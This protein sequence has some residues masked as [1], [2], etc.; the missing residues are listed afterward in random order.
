MREV[1]QGQWDSNT[2]WRLHETAELPPAALCTAVF[3][4]ALTTEAEIVLARSA[5]GWGLVG[6][7][8]EPGETAFQ[9]L[10]RES[11]EEGGFTPDNP[12]LFGVMEIT[13]QQPVL[14]QHSSTT[15]Y[16]FPR[17]YQLYY[18][19]TAAKPLAKPTGEEIMESQIFSL[20]A[21]REL[22]TPDYPI[23]ELGYVAY[24]QSH[25]A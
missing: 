21:A 6:G 18:H 9:A 15:R 17:S 1:L 5:R 3:C 19:A 24:Q 25:I 4:V 22:H 16:P 20:E 7:H 12:Q 14:R 10:A 13:S 23:A 8:I 11:L 2:Q